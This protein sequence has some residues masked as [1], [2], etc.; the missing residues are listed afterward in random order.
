MYIY[1]Y[2]YTD[3]LIDRQI[4]IYRYIERYTDKIN[5]E[6][7]EVEMLKCEMGSKE[8]DHW[9]IILDIEIIVS[10]NIQ[11]PAYC[12]EKTGCKLSQ[13]SCK[14]RIFKE[15]KIRKMEKIKLS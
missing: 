5:I 9:N 4:Y 14:K 2:T 15:R 1:I 8:K 7:E 3:R 6:H 10:I 11:F 13:C 12:E